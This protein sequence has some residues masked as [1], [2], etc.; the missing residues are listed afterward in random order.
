[1]QGIKSNLRCILDLDIVMKLMSLSRLLLGI[2]VVLSLH[3]HSVAQDDPKAREVVEAAIEAM[4]GKS[5]LQVKNSHSQG[6][7]YGFDKEERTRAFTHFQDWTV[8]EPIKWRFQ[9]GKGEKRRKVT[10][11]N[12]EIVKGWI[13]EGEAHV[14]EIPGETV[15]RFGSL[16]G[17][18]MDVLFRKRLDEEGMHLYYYGP[19]DIAGSGEYVAVEFLDA[20][21][22]AIVIFFDRQTHLPSKW[23]THRTNQLGVRQKHEQ[24]LYNWHTIQGVH[25]PLRYDT[26]VDG[27]KTTQRE[28]EA[29][30]FN[31]DIPP[32]H[33]LEPKPKQ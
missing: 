9:L 20:T 30:S 12:L 33:F 4:G 25:T 22:N 15:K 18:D 16:A 17:Q 2:S 24:Q 11:Y 26:F 5:Y 1:L 29:I 3:V 7:Y 6:L 23:E 8:Y 10:I 13:L 14:E 21:N 27:K 31:V 32:E 28:L 19:Q